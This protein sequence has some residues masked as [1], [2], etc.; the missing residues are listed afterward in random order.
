MTDRL[1]Q[2][3]DPEYDE[4][5]GPW[6][7]AKQAA[8]YMGYESTKGFYADVGRGLIPKYQLGERRLRFHRDELDEVLL[9]K[10]VPALRRFELSSRG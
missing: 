6:L 3:K 1:D 7:N 4:G 2:Q 10:R 8:A 5:A 9:S